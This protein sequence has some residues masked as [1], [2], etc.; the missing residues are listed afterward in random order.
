MALA[1]AQTESV[2]K[3]AE[4]VMASPA[5]SLSGPKRKK[6]GEGYELTPVGKRAWD[7]CK[8][9][10]E[11]ARAAFSAAGEEGDP[12]KQRDAY[13]RA[14]FQAGQAMSCVRTA[15]IG[16]KMGVAPIIKPQ[17]PKKPKQTPQDEE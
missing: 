3:A 2:I 6:A 7:H 1:R 16:T 8:I 14:G 10:L 17:K 9:R 11:G 4:K 15:K 5:D 12:L 13:V